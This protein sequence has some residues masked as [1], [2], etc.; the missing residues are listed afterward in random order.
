[1]SRDTPKVFAHACPKKTHVLRNPDF[2]AVRGV[3]TYITS[4]C[5]RQCCRPAFS[6]TRSRAGIGSM[7]VEVTLGSR[8]ATVCYFADS[9]DTPFS[10]LQRQIVTSRAVVRNERAPRHFVESDV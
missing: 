4:G 3:K 10:F 7:A 1:M 5:R 6:H 9:A 8:S 2:G